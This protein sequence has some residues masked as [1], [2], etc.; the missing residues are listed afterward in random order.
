[1]IKVYINKEG[2]NQIFKLD[3][4]IELYSFISKH[5]KFLH[6]VDGP[7]IE[8]TRTP[9]TSFTDIDIWWIDGKH[10]KTKEEWENY[11]LYY[12]MNLL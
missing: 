3:N 2:R 5:Y 9:P 7:A 6:R 4:S 11:L 10:F 1:M 12:K 8:I